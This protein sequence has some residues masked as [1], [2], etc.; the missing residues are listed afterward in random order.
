MSAELV[1][2]LPAK[3]IKKINDIRTNSI[4]A[5]E[6][7]NK[8]LDNFDGTVYLAGNAKFQS[9]EGV[10]AVEDALEYFEELQPVKPL[11]V[12]PGLTKAAQEHALYLA[13][14]G[15]CSHTGKDKSTLEDRLSV[16]GIWRGHISE[17]LAFQYQEA[18]DY[19]LHWIVNDGVES[20]GDRKQLVSSNFGKIGVALANH[21]TQGLIAVVVLAKDFVL[22]GKDGK[23]PEGI[24]NAPIYNDKMMDDIPEDI[25][26][27]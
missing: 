23:L 25:K 7:L 22:R 3:I 15:E 16:E 2:T 8:R 14:T 21:S 26:E 9:L 19:V 4:D 18:D 11:E 12:C 17:L 20:R 1:K 5:K 6:L 24:D 13:E 27:L 10:E